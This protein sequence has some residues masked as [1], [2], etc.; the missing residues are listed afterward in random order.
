MCV[1]SADWETERNLGQGDSCS[2][3]NL[4]D[5]QHRPRERNGNHRPQR[6][7]GT[8]EQEECERKCLSP[9]LS[10][11]HKSP[12]V[13]FPGSLSETGRGGGGGE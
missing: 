10:R 2:K 3:D 7:V 8:V 4:V 11:G 5:I 9:D 12:C 1:Y 6:R 13:W